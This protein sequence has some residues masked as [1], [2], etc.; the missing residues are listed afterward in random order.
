M[1]ISDLDKLLL[2]SNYA[3]CI[4]CNTESEQFKQVLGDWCVR[5]CVRMRV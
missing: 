3:K 2:V 1:Q 5:V 4:L